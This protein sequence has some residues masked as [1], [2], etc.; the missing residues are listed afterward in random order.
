MILAASLSNLVFKGLAVALLG[1][2]ELAK[3]IAL[4]FGIAIAG[5]LAILFLW[6]ST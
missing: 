3:R 5:G 2:R 6:P 1:S 4:L